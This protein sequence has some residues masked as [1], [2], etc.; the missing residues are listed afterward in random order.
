MCF[1]LATQAVISVEFLISLQTLGLLRPGRF[2]NKVIIFY[3]QRFKNKVIIF[4]KQFR[5]THFIN[6]CHQFI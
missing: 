3:K 6:N 4:Y 2:K 1:A 5:A